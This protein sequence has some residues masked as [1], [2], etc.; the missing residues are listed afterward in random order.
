MAGAESSKR[1]HLTKIAVE[2][3]PPPAVGHLVVWDTKLPGFAVRVSLKGRRTYF[4]HRRLKSGRQVKVTIGRHGTPFTCEQARARAKELLGD[5]AAGRDP[6]APRR[7][8]R[9][10]EKERRE[11]P[12]VAELCATY[13]EEHARPYK[14]ASSLESDVRIIERHIR[15]RIGQML[16]ADVTSSTIRQVH[17]EIT[18]AGHPIAAN[19]TVSLLSKVF[20]F[21]LAEPDVWRLIRNPAQRL[22]RN[23]ENRRE[24]FLSPEEIGRL[25]AALRARWDEP[26]AKAIALLLITGARRGELLNA[27]WDQIDF[28]RGRWTKPSAHTKQKK[29]HIVPLSPPAVRVLTEMPMREGYIFGPALV[30][31]LRDNWEAVRDEAGLK[32]VRLHDL[33]H[34]YASILA[35]AGLSLVMIGQLLGHT[36]PTTT[37]RYAHLLDDQLRAA[38]GRVGSLWEAVSQGDTASILPLSGC[39]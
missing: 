39:R 15:P 34:S 4:V 13:L 38:T 33:R 30:W 24:R 19:R 28:E 37:A 1:S 25:S 8:A 17:R 18:R 29:L 23:G 21:A 22:P 6:S 11:A 12:T 10:A 2:A 5:I 3:V 20:N 14:R 27:T 31:R 9:K 26:A 35:G 7:E 36:Q 32:G 16:V